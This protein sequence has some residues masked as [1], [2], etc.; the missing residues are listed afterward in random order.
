MVA[1]PNTYKGDYQMIIKHIVE[2]ETVINDDSTDETARAVLSMPENTR[3]QFFNIAGAGM[4]AQLLEKTKVNEGN[5]W[6]ELRV[7][8]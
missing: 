8:K 4:I 2:L 7:A 1:S 6:A 3:Q 5:S